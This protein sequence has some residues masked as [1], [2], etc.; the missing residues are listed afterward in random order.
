MNFPYTDKLL[1]REKELM[2]QI[3]AEGGVEAL[4][5]YIS[6]MG[7]NANVFTPAQLKERQAQLKEQMVCFQSSF[8]FCE[9]VDAHLKI[10]IYTQ[11]NKI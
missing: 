3:A 7:M 11:D 2:Q 8:A 6:K 4:Q 10:K 9:F 1:I 5:E